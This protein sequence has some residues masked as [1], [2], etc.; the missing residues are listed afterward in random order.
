MDKAKIEIKPGGIYLPNLNGLRCIAAFLVLVHHVEQLRWLSGWESYWEIPFF[1]SVGKTAVNLFF[2]LSG[3]LITFLLIKEKEKVGDI[4][5]KDFYYR[6]ILRIWPLYYFVVI[7]SFFVFPQFDIFRIQH[8]HYDLFYEN[9]QVALLLFGLFLSNFFLIYYGFIPHVTQV[10]SIGIEEQFYLIWPWF[11][12]YAPSVPRVILYFIINYNLLRVVFKVLH[13]TGYIHKVIYFPPIDCLA[14]GGF[15]ALIFLGKVKMPFMEYFQTSGFQW[16]ILVVTSGLILSGINIPFI[17][18][19]VY[20]VL[21]GFLLLG[22]SSDKSILNLEFQPFNY[23]GK[24]SYGIYMYHPVVIAVCLN[25]GNK[26][27]QQNSVFIYTSS[28]LLTTLVASL[29]YR[30]FEHRFISMKF[31]FSKIISGDEAKI[32]KG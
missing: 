4:S 12:K 8:F 21:F 2:V 6:R 28:I 24:I 32:E 15:F 31:K 7:C 9:F 30:I 26:L 18:Y 19:Q 13:S 11:I 14:I 27:N 25:V 29:S 22:I 16:F 10:W 3:Y 5:I 1:E 20:S 23:L 17:N